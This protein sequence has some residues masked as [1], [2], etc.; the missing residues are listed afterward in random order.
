MN[1]SYYLFGVHMDNIRSQHT[2][3]MKMSDVCRAHHFSFQTTHLLIIMLSY[4]QQRD[5]LICLL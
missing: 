1:R 4:D 2:L 3:K 5:S